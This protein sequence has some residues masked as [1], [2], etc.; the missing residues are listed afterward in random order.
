MFFLPKWGCGD[1]FHDHHVQ[2][3]CHGTWPVSTAVHGQGLTPNQRVGASQ[4]L[5][6][7]MKFQG[8]IQPG[9][10]HHPL[11]QAWKREQKTW[12]KCRVKTCSTENMMEKQLQKGNRILSPSLPAWRAA[13]HP[14]LHPKVGGAACGMIRDI[15]FSHSG[16]MFLLWGSGGEIIVKKIRRNK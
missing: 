12:K 6:V 4:P 16:E 7:Q 5:Q 2:V 3:T 9:S 8:I 10:H 13:A 11:A 14:V 1:C 15:Y